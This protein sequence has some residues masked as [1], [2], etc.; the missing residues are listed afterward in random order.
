MAELKTQPSEQDIDT[1][2]AAV[3]DEKRREDCRAVVALMAEVTG[4]APRL[5]S[6]GMIG[7]G[8][9]HY[10][11]DSGREGDWFLTG[12]SP[13]KQSLTIY[14]LPGHERYPELMARLGR[15]RTGKSCIYV[16]KLE[17]I[18]TTVLRELVERSVRH[19]RE[20]YD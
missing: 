2:L 9:Y 15:C 13:R 5:W 4:E 20:T 14:I 7:F 19:L 8:S 18:D 10:V 12:V 17:D 11:Y 16:N 6:G 3:E 1:F